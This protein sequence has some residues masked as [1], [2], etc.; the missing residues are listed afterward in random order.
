MKIIPPSLMTV[1]LLTS[2][3]IHAT[4]YYIDSTSGNDN[5]LGTELAPWKSISKVNGT[6]LKPADHIH[7]KRGA[8]WAETL[9]PP[10]SGT[11]SAPIVFED[12]GVGD[13]PVISGASGS[14]CI[15]WVTPRSNMT[16]RNL[17][18][19]DCGK[20][21]SSKVG[22]I[23]VWSDGGAS[24]NILIESM[25]IEGS[26]RWNIYM[27]GVTNVMIRNNVL[28]NAVLEHGIYIDGSLTTN[29]VLIEKNEIYGNA[30]MGIQ[31]NSN[32]ISRVPG[33]IIRYN[34]IYNCKMGGIN[35]I[36]ADG[37]LVNHNLIYGPMPSIYNGCDG[38]DTG[39]KYGAINGNYVNNTILTS[40]TSWATCFSNASSLGSPT[41]S[42]FINNICVHNATSGPAFEDD[43][44][45]GTSRLE[46]NLFYSTRGDVSIVRA[47]KTYSTFSSYLTAY[48]QDKGELFV[49]PLFVDSVIGNYSLM[50]NSPAVDSGI[51]MNITSDM[52]GNPIP[53][54]AG[55]DRGILE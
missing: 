22:G 2:M 51:F 49:D 37:A 29:N 9:L 13:L 19:L 35:N 36:G 16:F 1:I 14:G 42:T 5:N 38:A 3:N 10:V 7:F 54:G 27:A 28:R 45:A 52:A 15:R 44:S 20:N 40:G 41:Y 48:P 55:T 17:H 18:L 8:K 39:C 25:I 6:S 21:S 53:S 12:Y 23:S 24:N 46:S 50:V 32:A 4:D 34:K 33:I 47:G 30:S 43:E 26:Q 31:V 11:E